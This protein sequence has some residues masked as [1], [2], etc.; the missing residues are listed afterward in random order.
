MNHPSWIHQVQNT[1]TQ[2]QTRNYRQKR[3]KDIL[4]VD[5]WYV[6]EMGHQVF[7]AIYDNH[8]WV[9]FPCKIWDVSFR[10]IVSWSTVLTHKTQQ[11]TKRN[12]PFLK[13]E[14]HL[15]DII[16]SDIHPEMDITLYSLDTHKIIPTNSEFWK[17]FR[18]RI[19][20]THPLSLI[21]TY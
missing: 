18:N 17:Q 8:F 1:F 21:P 6:V 13:N 2:Y 19:P 14:I 5:D 10:I 4:N 12:H 20:S 11:F 3:V 16:R 7:N 9:S 15:K